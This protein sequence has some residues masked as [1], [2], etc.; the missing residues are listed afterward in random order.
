MDESI[1]QFQ[2]AI[3]IQPTCVKAHNNLG[4][5]LMQGNRL[6]AAGAGCEW[7]WPRSRATSSRS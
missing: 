3:A 6:D 4:V 2:R 7:P 5:A 1:K